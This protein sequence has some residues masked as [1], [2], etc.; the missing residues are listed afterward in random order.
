MNKKFINLYDCQ[1]HIYI[2]NI[3]HISAIDV[4]RSKVWV[5]EV[6]LELNTNN[7]K[8]LLDILAGDF[9]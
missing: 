9:E 8:R 5:D 6:L 3:N 2:I 4:D 7:I 1:G